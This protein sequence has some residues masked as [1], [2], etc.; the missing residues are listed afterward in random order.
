MKATSHTYQLSSRTVPGNATDDRLLSQARLK[1]PEG[2]VL[3]DLIAQA[4]GVPEVFPDQPEAR[5]ALQLVGTQTPSPALE[6][7]GRC[8]R[9]RS[10]EAGGT[11]GGG[12]AQALHGIN[13]PT[14]NHRLQAGHLAQWLDLPEP[15]ATLVRRLYLVTLS[16]PPRPEESAEWCARLASAGRRREAAEDLLWAL[17]NSREFLFNH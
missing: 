14:L 4:T 1:T 8:S 7:L 11:A 6:A 15:D 16:R 13:G 9:E 3:L 12:L 5:T 10:C 2:R 17:L